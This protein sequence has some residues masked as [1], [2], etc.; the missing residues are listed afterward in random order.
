[1]KLTTLCATRYGVWAGTCRDPLPVL[2]SH[3]KLVEKCGKA[4]ADRELAEVNKIRARVG[5]IPATT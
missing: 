1:M 5:V 2:W 3:A 4:H